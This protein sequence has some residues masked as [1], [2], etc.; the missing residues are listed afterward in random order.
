[1]DMIA[2]ITINIPTM[3]VLVVII[4]LI[5]FPFNPKR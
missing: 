3:I 4:L 5:F 2:F 1:M